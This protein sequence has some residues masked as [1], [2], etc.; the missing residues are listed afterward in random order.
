MFVL[1]IF[2]CPAQCAMPTGYAALS[3][4][5][6]TVASYST[7]LARSILSNGMRLIK[8]QCYPTEKR[9]ALIMRSVS[10]LTYR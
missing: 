1:M 3:V 4:L 10:C 5:C 9:R 2:T 7:R 8:F 6:V